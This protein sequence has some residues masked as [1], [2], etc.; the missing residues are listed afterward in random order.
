MNAKQRRVARRA[1]ARKLIRFTNGLALSFSDSAKA[2]TNGL[3]AAAVSIQGFADALPSIVRQMGI[4]AVEAEANLRRAI[5]AA[6]QPPPTAHVPDDTVATLLD[7]ARTG[8]EAD[9]RWLAAASGV[10]P[11]RIDE[12]WTG[13][14]ARV[15]R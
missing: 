2:V 3:R 14:R 10:R 15:A 11:E 13:T 1:D 9:F 6:A 7:Y 12:L 8:N 5:A 4:A